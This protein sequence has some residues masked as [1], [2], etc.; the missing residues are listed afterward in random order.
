MISPRSTGKTTNAAWTAQ[1][2]FDLGEPVIGFDCDESRQWTKWD[3]INE[4]PYTVVGAA[5]AKAHQTIPKV[6]PA[7]H[8][9]VAD[10]G[11]L[12]NHPNVGFSVCR[13]ADIAVINCAAT[14]SDYERLQRLPMKGK[15]EAFLEGTAPIRPSGEEIPAVVL[16]T[17]VQPGTTRVEAEIR[18]LLEADGYQVLKTVIPGIQRYAQTGE[19]MPIETRI[20][21]N[22]DPDS[23]APY[24]PNAAVHVDMLE[25]ISALG[26]F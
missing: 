6:L 4:F 1:A 18:G 13:I 8:W 15:E 3:E 17:R 16:L 14:L 26:V 23:E 9:G 19:G 21:P 11:H 20:E 2:L 25:E 22:D 12:E 10:V 24:G 5:S 7:D